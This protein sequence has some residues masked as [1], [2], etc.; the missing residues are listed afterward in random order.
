MRVIGSMPALRFSRNPGLALLGLLVVFYLAYQTAQLVIAGDVN[1]LAMSGLTFVAVA[2]VVAILNDWRRGLYFLL[3]WILFEDF[4]RK[5][6]GNNMAIFFAK[7]AFAV[8]LY[9]AFFAAKRKNL[10]KSFRPPFLVRV[11]RPQGMLFL[12]VDTFPI[13][14]G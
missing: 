3:G 1:T 10:V 9:L 2:I 13:S 14:A 7:D 6:L 5:Y 8:V 11:L 4:F 12:A